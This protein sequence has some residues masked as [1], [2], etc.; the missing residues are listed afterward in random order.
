MNHAHWTSRDGVAEKAGNELLG[1]HL[2]RGSWNTWMGAASNRLGTL[3]YAG[4][5]LQLFFDH[6]SK[7]CLPTLL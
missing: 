2:G 4:S 6:Q 7:M 1:K 5:S 3:P